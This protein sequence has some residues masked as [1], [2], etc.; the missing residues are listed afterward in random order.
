M[1][2]PAPDIN[3]AD[4]LAEIEENTGNER[5]LLAQAYFVRGVTGL[6]LI[7]PADYVEIMAILQ[8]KLGFPVTVANL[9][10][11]A[12]KYLPDSP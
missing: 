4:I 8:N 10:Q 7:T 3:K 5:L 1:D 2:N 12:D 11:A 6:G 9:D